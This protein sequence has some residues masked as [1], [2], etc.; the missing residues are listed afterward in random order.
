MGYL[1]Q[2]QQAVAG[3][4]SQCSQRRIVVISVQHNRQDAVLGDQQRDL[5]FFGFLGKGDDPIDG[6][7][8]VLEGLF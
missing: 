4:L 7:L 5:R 8:N 6:L 1:G 2:L 3:F